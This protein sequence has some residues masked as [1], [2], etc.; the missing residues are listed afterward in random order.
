MLLIE[1]STTTRYHQAHQAG[2]IT[3]HSNKS[4]CSILYLKHTVH[5]A[6]SI[7]CLILINEKQTENKNCTSLWKK[8]TPLEDGGVWFYLPD[9]NARHSW[10]MQG[11][12][13]LRHG[14]SDSSPIHG[15]TCRVPG[16]K[17]KAV[18]RQPWLYSTIS[19]QM[20]SKPKGNKFIL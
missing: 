17:I 11:A 9:T 20:H 8:V 3:T 19:L 1:L 6:K 16:E 10:G 7:Y 14:N 18:P 13:R 4:I 15:G 2:C 5:E 12:F